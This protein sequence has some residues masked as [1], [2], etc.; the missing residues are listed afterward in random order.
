M[1]NRIRAV[2]RGRAAS[3]EFGLAEPSPPA[4]AVS[5]YRIDG[6]CANERGPIAHKRIGTLRAKESSPPSFVT[7]DATSGR[8]VSGPMPKFARIPNIPGGRRPMRL[9]SGG[10]CVRGEYVPSRK[11]SKSSGFGL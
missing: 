9:L 7:T 4:D 8:D 10:R 2:P 1:C 11:T 5:M 3:S 6:T